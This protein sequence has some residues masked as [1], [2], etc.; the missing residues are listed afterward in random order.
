[1]CRGPRHRYAGPVFTGAP[2]L[3]LPGGTARV[4]VRVAA[5]I[6]GASLAVTAAAPAFAALDFVQHIGSFGT[7]PGQ[8]AYPTG[9]AIGPS[10]DLFVSDGGNNRLVR[11]T[12][13]GQYVATIGG[14]GSTPGRFQAPDYLAFSPVSG[15]LFVMDKGNDRVQRLH[16]DGTFVLE[17]GS[18]GT[19]PGQFDNP[20]GVH[21]DA[22]GNVWITSQEQT[23]VQKFTETGQYLGEWG[24]PGTANGQFLLPHGIASDELGNIFVV[25]PYRYDVQMFDP[26]GAWLMKFGSEGS[27]PG[28]LIHPEDITWSRGRIVIVDF[29]HHPHAGKV[30]A[31]SA[32]S[33]AFQEVMAVGPVGLCDMCFDNAYDAVDDGAG[34]WYVLEWA[35]HRIKKLH[36]SGLGA[37]DAL[38]ADAGLRALGEPVPNPSRGAVRFDLRVPNAAGP[39]ELSVFDVRGLPVF[40]RAIDP[41]AMSRVSWDGRGA[42]GRSLGAGVYFVALR[43]EGLSET[44]KVVRIR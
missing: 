3:P 22:S 43:G 24:V 18:L 6:V 5:V 2:L 31:F 26:S 4:Q 21:V 41:A 23:R 19:G 10:G 32:T 44:R 38:A 36:E 9:V 7:G 37:G 17:W 14:G 28:Q 8:L 39:C 34:N 27:N 16:E 20:W 25:D 12:T 42:D 11:F 40:T 33:G 15:D 1:M 35:N 13:D 29:W 30:S